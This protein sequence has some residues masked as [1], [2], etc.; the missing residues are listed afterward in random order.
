MHVRTSVNL[1]R[2]KHDGD[3]ERYTGK[4]QKLH[5]FWE[6]KT[7]QVQKVGAGEFCNVWAL[8]EVKSSGITYKSTP[9]TLPLHFHQAI[10]ET[11][12]ATLAQG[13]YGWE[14]TDI[15]VTL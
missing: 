9:G 4:I 13:V 3:I 2:R 5:V 7:V 15:V 6:G 11:V 10:E 8:K 1:Q 14:V 12:R